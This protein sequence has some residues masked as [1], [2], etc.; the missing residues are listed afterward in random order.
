[1]IKRPDCAFRRTI[2]PAVLAGLMT[3]A[4]FPT[5][6]AAQDEQAR[7]GTGGLKDIVVTAQRREENLREVPIAVNAI[8]SD[9][10]RQL[11]IADTNSLVQA[12]PSL[13]FTRSGPS[14]IFIIRGVSTPNGAAGEEGSTA[15]YVD[16]VYMADL[17]ST[18]SKFNNIERVEA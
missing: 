1:M 3:A 16:D 4:S 8:D 10:L 15:V 6:A 7:A 13:N 5:L 2:Q 9:S 12:V 18:I 11:G 17:S 14:G